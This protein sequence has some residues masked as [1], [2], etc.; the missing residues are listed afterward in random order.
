MRRIAI[1]RRVTR[2][3]GRLRRSCGNRRR[4]PAWRH[5]AAELLA[6]A[7]IVLRICPWGWHRRLPAS[8]LPQRVARAYRL[9]PFRALWAVE[10]LGFRYA[11]TSPAL[12]AGKPPARLA[13]AELPAESLLMLHVGLG[14]ALARRDLAACGSELKTSAAVDRFLEHAQGSAL[15]GYLD[16]VAEPLGVVARYEHPRRVAAIGRALGRQAPELVPWYWHGV[17]RCHLFLPASF[18][19]LAEAS[20]RA[21]RR[22]AREVP[23]GVARRH[24]RVGWSCGLTLVHMRQPWLVADLLRRHG[25]QIESAADDFAGDFR[26]GIAEAVEL[27]REVT[28]GSGEL[29]E[30]FLAHRPAAGRRTADRWRRLVEQPGLAALAAPATGGETALSRARAAARRMA[31]SPA[32]ASE[33]EAAAAARIA[34]RPHREWEREEWGALARRRS[35]GYV[36]RERLGIPEHLVI[37]R[38]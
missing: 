1:S 13:D 21:A 36:G 14:M 33:V 23:A 25:A 7:A 9:G 20:W 12:A 16:A 26:E 6:R 15:P 31:A 24:A 8:R 5:L 22:L 34:P 2:P 29:V 3:T 35:A 37:A 10:A 17:G 19:P 32:P 18:L 30:A 38:A 11:A 27:R 28:P 4:P